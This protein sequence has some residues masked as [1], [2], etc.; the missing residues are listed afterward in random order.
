MKPVRV[1]VFTGDVPLP[2]PSPSCL[3]LLTWLTMEGL[4][5][6]V[7]TPRGAP[8]SSTK[9]VPYVE[10][11]SGEILAESQV[12][13]ERLA[14]GALDAHLP[15][16]G[17]SQALLIRRLIEDHLY[18]VLLT[19]RWLDDAQWPT[20]RAQYFGRLPAP[21]RWFL[22][23]ILRRNVRRDAWG[24]GLGRR[25]L[26]DVYDEGVRDVEA[27]ADALGDQTWFLGEPSSLDATAFGTLANLWIQPEDFVVR[28][29]L[30]GR[31]N[32]VSWLGR[33]AGRAWPASAGAL[34]LPTSSAP[35]A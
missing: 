33:V 17:R 35:P 16:S 22:P 30:V 28:R 4:P 32:L 6:E 8:R 5:F 20:T 13:M 21:L 27:L 1:V 23:W 25:P 18:F 2:S 11:P 10:L 9:K 14:G 34:G 31:P 24:Q 3:K 7:V 26:A 19:H 12:I 15:P 29:A